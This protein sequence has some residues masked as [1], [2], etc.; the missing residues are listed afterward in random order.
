ML[1]SVT[2][3]ESSIARGLKTEMPWGLGPYLSACVLTNSNVISPPKKLSSE[4]KGSRACKL[5]NLLI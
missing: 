4:G 3:I 1:Q 5:I 2:G